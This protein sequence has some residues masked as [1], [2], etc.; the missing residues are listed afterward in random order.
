MNIWCWLTCSLCFLSVFGLSFMAAFLCMFSLHCMISYTLSL[1][2]CLLFTTR[3]HTLTLHS[4]QHQ[5]IP[6]P[7]VTLLSFTYKKNKQPT[8]AHIFLC[9]HVY[10][11]CIA[12]VAGPSSSSV[13]DDITDDVTLPS[14]QSSK[15]RGKDTAQGNDNQTGQD[16]HSFIYMWNI[17]PDSRLWSVISKFVLIWPL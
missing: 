10:S 15:P 1:H 17:H 7:F 13:P 2:V 4:F 11:L 12:V 8:S 3:R 6:S 16:S 9:P 5:L 14:D